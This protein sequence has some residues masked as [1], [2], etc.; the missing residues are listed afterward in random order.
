MRKNLVVFLLALF[1]A[2]AAFFVYKDTINSP[3]LLNKGDTN[4]EITTTKIAIIDSGANLDQVNYDHNIKIKQHNILDGSTDISDTDNNGTYLFSALYNDIYSLNLANDVLLIKAFESSD[5]IK[6]AN[7]I[8]AINYAVENKVSVINLGY[9]LKQSEKLD[10][11]INKALE[12]NIKIVTIKKDEN[13][14]P[15][16]LK[17]VI[18]VTSTEDTKLNSTIK[19]DDSISVM[20]RNN[21]CTTKTTKA[22]NV[23]TASGYLMNNDLD[24]KNELTLKYNY[25]LDVNDNN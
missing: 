15:A 3:F 20:C 1:I 16:N 8:K 17:N 18:S 11:A 4:N 13:S 22:F 10:K 12:A 14:Y 9:E 21:K 6:N 7:I 19:V 23:I 2:G 24:S 5:S 25:G